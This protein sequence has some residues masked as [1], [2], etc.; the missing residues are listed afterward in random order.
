MA[1]HS[2]NIGLKPDYELK[3]G[4]I[5]IPHAVIVSAAVKGCAEADR[6]VQHFSLAG[7]KN[8]V[9]E[10]VRG[11]TVYGALRPGGRNFAICEVPEKYI[12]ITVCLK[13]GD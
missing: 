9:D 11:R 8:S 10:I 6:L 5:R 12:V 3:F 4:E 13:F 1:S 2:L 7:L